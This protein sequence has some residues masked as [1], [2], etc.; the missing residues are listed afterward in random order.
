MTANTPP[1]STR[2]EAL[3]A[4][5]EAGYLCDD[6]TATVVWLAGMLGRP[7]LTEG[8]PGVGKTALAQAIARSTGRRLIRLQC[9]EG[10]DEAKALYEWDYGKQILY[11]QLLRHTVM[12][13]SSDTAS[14]D[15]AM[16]AI[17][18]QES[19]F[20]HTRFLTARP[21]LQSLRS[22]RPTVLLIDEVDRSDPELEA[23]LLEVL[24]DYQASIPE[25]GTIEAR[26][27]PYVVL[28]SNATR[29]VTEALR[30]R[31]LYLDLA[32]PS[33]TREMAIINQKAPELS[34]RLQ[35]S[36]VDFVARLRGLPLRKTPSIAESADW[37]QTLAILGAT[38]LEADVVRTTLGVL[39]KHSEDQALVLRDLTAYLNS[40]EPRSPEALPDSPRSTNETG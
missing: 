1:Y 7:L 5:G 2:D 6:R 30:R 22:E 31:C 28:T 4:L 19:A 11:T 33:R 21:L 35:L 39:L 20:F 13:L 24:S 16:A 38:R 17:A 37:A 12:R 25:L 3:R 34:A 9:Y 14:V 40:A 27:R 8:P 10:L 32:Y 23:L 29:E 18:D 26:T 36:L 15:A